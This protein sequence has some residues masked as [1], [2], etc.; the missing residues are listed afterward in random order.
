VPSRHE[1]KYY[2]LALRAS[3]EAKYYKLWSEI[4]QIRLFRL[5]ICSST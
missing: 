5:Q 4:L 3:V 1:A 2:K